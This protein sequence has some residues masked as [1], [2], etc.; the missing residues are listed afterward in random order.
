MD[1]E[2]A[3]RISKLRGIERKLSSYDIHALEFLFHDV[4]STRKM[5]EDTK[6]STILSEI[7]T[8][9]Y[10]EHVV[11]GLARVGRKD[12]AQKLIDGCSN[13]ASLS[14]IIQN[15]GDLEQTRLD[16]F[17]ALLVHIAD[18][19][20][21]EDDLPHLKNIAT[22]ISKRRLSKV[23][24][25]LDFFNLL[26]EGGDLKPDTL[27]EALLEPMETLG[28]KSWKKHS[29]KISGFKERLHL[30]E[31]EKL[32][33]SLITTATGHVA[34]VEEK[35][36]KHEDNTE[37]VLKYLHETVPKVI[38]TGHCREETKET[39]PLNITVLLDRE[40][41]K[42]VIFNTEKFDH[43]RSHLTEQTSRNRTDSPYVADDIENKLRFLNFNV[44]HIT[45]C[46]FEKIDE[47]L[48][49]LA[50]EVDHGD[51]DCVLIIII[52]HGRDGQLRDAHGN[53][54]DLAPLR[55]RF[56]A[57][58]TSAR[59]PELF[60]IQVC[61][62]FDQQR[63]FTERRFC[64][65]DETKASFISQ[66]AD[67]QAS[68]KAEHNP[69]TEDTHI[70]QITQ[71]LNE[72]LLSSQ[73]EGTVESLITQIADN[74]SIVDTIWQTDNDNTANSDKANDTVAKVVEIGQ[75]REETR[76]SSTIPKYHRTKQQPAK[77]VGDEVYRMRQGKALIF[78]IEKFNRSRS[79]SEN[80]TLEDRRGSSVDAD[81]IEYT[82]R[83]LNF[84]VERFNDNEC[85][86][87]VI[88]GRH[89]RL[90]SD[91]DLRNFD[92]IA[93]FILT[94]GRD[95]KLLDVNGK[96]FDLGQLRSYFIASECVSLAGKPKMFF[97][98][99]CQ[100]SVPQG[101]HIETDTVVFKPRSRPTPSSPSIPDP[102]EAPPATPPCSSTADQSPDEAD[103]L[104]C[105]STPPGYVSYRDVEKGSWFIST[106]ITTLE[107]NCNSL[108]IVEIL[109][110]TNRMLVKKTGNI[111]DIPCV[112]SLEIHSSLR[113]D[114]FLRIIPKT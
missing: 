5:H 66:I 16:E 58:S 85:T 2:K 20:T 10:D 53:F 77:K 74:D 111:K 62:E 60:F 14:Q 47:R 86:I 17:R 12:L 11:E 71:G 73:A 101:R 88:E 21:D 41:R 65:A 112:Q 49:R 38:E 90:A 61:Q 50:L 40:K 94:H 95:G 18:E 22:N 27:E 15:L 102:P 113:G 69:I 45:D 84:D 35:L 57:N 59:K 82:F 67:A 55:K 81:R 33:A 80:L 46:T 4:V 70:P 63:N 1:V 104:I 91:I 9:G 48:I 26:M 37:S 64:E 79:H 29:R 97:I 28:I 39:K 19:L 44:E 68:Q 96:H 42:A 93:I 76:D 13:E 32:N 54:F 87:E 36:R 99:A 43:S 3:K 92:C 78:N 105:Y 8:D 7:A 89:R 98:Q 31:A 107:E 34:D 24:T 52:A 100:G 114:L 103:F 108:G 23:S 56:R 109:H 6:G 30:R 25:I 83:G 51:F 110:Q 75:D 106:F 72:R